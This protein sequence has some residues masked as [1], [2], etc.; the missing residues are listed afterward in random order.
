M[1]KIVSQ[2]KF[3]AVHIKN[4]PMPTNSPMYKIF[5]QGQMQL[6][7][8][9]Q[10]CQISVFGLQFQTPLQTEILEQSYNKCSKTCYEQLN[11]PHGYMSLSKPQC[12]AS[13]NKLN[14]IYIFIQVHPL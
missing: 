5:N 6:P 11:V 14:N 7:T 9:P 8:K 1:G 4:W 10:G 13:Y 2:V 3:N 12:F